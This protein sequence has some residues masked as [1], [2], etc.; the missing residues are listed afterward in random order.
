MENGVIETKYNSL[1]N[2]LR[3]RIRLDRSGS[4][5]PS[6]RSLMRTYRVSQS[7]ITTALNILEQDGLIIRKGGSGVYTKQ[8]DHQVVIC[9]CRTL[10]ASARDDAWER[11]LR[12]HCQSRNWILTTSRFDPQ[13]ANIFADVVK[14]DAYV[15]LP[16]LTTYQSPLLKRLINDNIPFVTLGRDTSSVRLDFV[17][18]DDTT[19]INEYVSGLVKRGH[20][21][22]AFFSCEPPFYE[23]KK[24]ID[25]FL[26]AC[27]LM[28]VKSSLVLDADAQYGQDSISKSEK[29]LREYL[30]SIKNKQLPFTALLTSSIS[31]SI[32]AFKVFHDAGYNIPDDIS[33]CC[34]GCDERAIYTVPALTNSS[35]TYN[36]GSEAT[37]QIIEKRLSGDKTPLLFK[38]TNHYI[39]WREST[40][41]R[42]NI[43]DSL[44][45]RKRANSSQ[46]GRTKPKS[47]SNNKTKL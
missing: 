39:N 37:L 23:V 35:P 19:A 20:E 21:S 14:A 25:T 17:A 5:L 36:D 40:P 28:Q 22:I 3:E 15:L 34:L 43:S 41:Q 4:K 46:V 47:K 18:G 16:E 9:F 30:K 24:R 13:H 45:N 33:L 11:S 7:T 2:L 32:P 38:W 6:I 44:T 26:N 29:F 10:E 1:S 31:G 12:K 27:Q 42:C 8:T